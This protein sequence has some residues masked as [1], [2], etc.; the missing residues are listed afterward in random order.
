MQRKNFIKF[1]SNS[2]LVVGHKTIFHN[3]IKEKR[4][5]LEITDLNSIWDNILGTVFDL[6]SEIINAEIEIATKAGLIKDQRRIYEDFY[7]RV[8]QNDEWQAIFF[9]NYPLLKVKLENKI[10]HIIDYVNFVIDR[11]SD[12]IDLLIQKGL[13]TNSNLTTIKFTS[14]D[15]HNHTCTVLLKFEAGEEIYFKPKSLE[16]DIFINETIS[17]GFKRLINGYEK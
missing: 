16:G 14:G 5:N 1:I 6:F 15:T 2:D 4:N 12:D 9:E 8:S 3:L 10:K 13:C 7:L 11:V 17:D